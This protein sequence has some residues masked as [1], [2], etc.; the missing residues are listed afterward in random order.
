MKINKS[1]LTTGIVVVVILSVY[2]YENQGRNIITPINIQADKL[3]EAYFAG[4]CFWCVESDF[5]KLDGVKEV[6]SGYMGGEEK[7]S[8]YKDV[9]SGLT[10]H[11]E[12]VKVLY[13]PSS[14]SYESLVWWFF[15]HIDPT[16]EGGSFYDRGH[17]YTSA[18]YY[19]NE[20]E[21][22]IAESV[23]KE[24]EEEDV[25][26]KPIVTDIEKALEFYQAEDYHQDYYKNN[27]LR[28]RY[29]REGSGRDKYIESI[30]GSGEF[31]DLGIT[32]NP[33]SDFKKPSDEELKNLLT[34]LQYEI[35]QKEGTET[36]F[37]NEYDQNKEKGIYVDIISGEPLFSSTHKYDSGTGWPSFY[38]PISDE[39]IVKKTDYKLILPRVEIK[40]KY[41]DSHIGH[42]FKDG[43][44]PTGLRYCMNS[45]AMK[46]IP[47]EEM[48]QKG[49]LNY[50]YLFN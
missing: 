48:E 13:D 14:V 35:T 9:S 43:P 41:A 18:I 23:I 40:S 29:Y 42:V 37:K 26:K 49:Y 2:L 24:L 33:W 8:T 4:G 21:K 31:N 39:F 32:K 28:Y 30:W 34:K 25:F 5:E 16:D 7:D 12:L 27:P 22:I 45:S 38:R 44:E 1:I 11:R 17:Q 10:K 36:P 50:L 15:R 3:S 19:Q 47:L 20:N 46:F 6:I